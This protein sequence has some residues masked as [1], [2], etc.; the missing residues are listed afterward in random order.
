MTKTNKQEVEQIKA[1]LL[2]LRIRLD[3]LQQKEYNN[4]INIP[5]N[6]QDKQSTAICNEVI[7]KESSEWIQEIIEQLEEIK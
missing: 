6:F 7:L 3:I 2:S 1:E 4:L 5:N